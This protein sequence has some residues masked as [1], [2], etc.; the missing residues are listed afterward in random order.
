MVGVLHQVDIDAVHR[1]PSSL[2]IIRRDTGSACNDAHVSLSQCTMF[3]PEH[4][5]DVGYFIPKA[6]HFNLLWSGLKPPVHLLLPDE[7]RV[8]LER[9]F[10]TELMVVVQ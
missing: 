2:D 8:P 3:F 5:T 6:G 4:L 1:R 7:V 10:E 9:M